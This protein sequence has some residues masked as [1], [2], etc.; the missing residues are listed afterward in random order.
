MGWLLSRGSH[1]I[2]PAI[3]V[4]PNVQ[5]Q[6][7]MHQTFPVQFHPIWSHLTAV[8]KPTPL[9]SIVLAGWGWS[10]VGLAGVGEVGRGRAGGEG[11]EWAS[12]N[13]SAEGNKREYAHFHNFSRNYPRRV[14][15]PDNRAFQNLSYRLDPDLDPDPDLFS[16]PIT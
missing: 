9:R 6:S 2:L 5:Q 8:T 7:R 1:S 14:P 12:K 13:L 4:H 10:L 15:N 11:T 16:P 3:Y